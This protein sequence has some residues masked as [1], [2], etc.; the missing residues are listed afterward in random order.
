MITPEHFGSL[1]NNRSF[2]KVRYRDVRDMIDL[3]IPPE[4]IRKYLDRTK[5]VLNYF[6]GSQ[7]ALRD[8]ICESIEMGLRGDGASSL[9][10]NYIAEHFEDDEPEH[11]VSSSSSKGTARAN[12]GLPGSI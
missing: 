5:G 10:R 7:I 3:D 4:D 6:L 1:P 12:A 8:A 11:R 2:C 9:V